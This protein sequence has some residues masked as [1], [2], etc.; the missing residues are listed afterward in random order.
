MKRIALALWHAAALLST[1]AAADK[2]IRNEL[3][4]STTEKR[5]H[6]SSLRRREL[7]ADTDQMSHSSERV[8]QE[9]LLFDFLRMHCT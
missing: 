5:N 1:Q 3:V 2:T 6:H 4:S 9:Q 7:K 8:S